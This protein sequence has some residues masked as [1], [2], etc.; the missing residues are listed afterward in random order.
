MGRHRVTTRAA[1]LTLLALVFGWAGQVMAETHYRYATIDGR[2]LFYREAGD[3]DKPT[4]L[5]L[6]G[7]PSS[8][9]M[10]RDL[11]PALEADFHVLAPDYPGMG[12]SEA[13]P[14]DGPALTFDALARSIDR[15]VQQQGVKNAVL[16]MQDFGGPVGMRLATLHPQWVRG[17]I[18]QNTPVSLDGWEPSRLQG[19]QASSGPQTPEKRAAA[20]ARVVLATDLFLYRHGARDPDSL[21]PDAWTNDAFALG[22]P[23]KRRVMT[24]LQLDIV[25][26]LAL[27]PQWQA[28]LQKNRPTTLVVWGDGDPIFVPQG[29][30]AI[31][32][33]VPGAQIQHYATG[34]FALEE[35]HGDI[36]QRI[37][38]AFARQ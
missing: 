16:Y 26:N 17:L 24:D 31:K 8:S 33:F 32:A 34:H 35:E 30:D 18:I 4:I 1:C 19:V 38:R 21:N 13:P 10:F 12:N 25:S 20:Q 28:Y 22:D 37:V 2:K 5:L 15:F 11:I 23:D 6:H 29:A 3:V 27:Y 36:A 14:A 7:F 9:H